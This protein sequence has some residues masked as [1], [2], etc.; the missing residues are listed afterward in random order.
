MTSS[1]DGAATTTTT[2]WQQHQC[3]W[4]SHTTTTM[5]TNVNGTATPP[6]QWWPVSMV[7]HDNDTYN[8]TCV[9]SATTTTMKTKMMRSM[10]NVNGDDAACIDGVATTTTWWWQHQHWWCSHHHIMTATSIDPQ[11]GHHPH[12]HNHNGQDCDHDTDDPQLVS[13]PWQRHQQWNAHGKCHCSTMT[14][15][16]NN[17]NEGHA[18]HTTH[19]YIFTLLVTYSSLDKLYWPEGIPVQLAWGLP[20]G[21][22]AAYLCVNPDP[23]IHTHDITQTHCVGTGHA[24]NTH[25]WP[26][27]L[28]RCWPLHKGKIHIGRILTDKTNTGK[29]HTI[30]IFTHMKQTSIYHVL[31][32]YTPSWY[33]DY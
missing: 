26:M 7:R 24:P 2:Q 13:P 9:D 16:E 3:Q 32:Q 29:I 17:N 20:L 28:P 5:V 22:F 12:D 30:L 10:N 14:T 8:D 6:P 27:L 4:H 21:I 19:I 15:T 23:W 25:G 1:I 18:N 31:V 33:I 11:D